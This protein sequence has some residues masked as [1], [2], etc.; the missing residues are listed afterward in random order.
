[1]NTNYFHTRA[2]KVV[3]LLNGHPVD[4][5]GVDLLAKNQLP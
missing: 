3:P 5:K 1:M 4:R 2:F